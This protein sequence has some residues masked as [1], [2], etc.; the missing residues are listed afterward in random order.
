MWLINQRRRLLQKM[1]ANH[2]YKCEEKVLQWADSTCL[3]L[4]PPQLTFS[5]FQIS[6][7]LILRSMD[8]NSQNFTVRRIQDSYVIDIFSPTRGRFTNIQVFPNEIRNFVWLALIRTQM[9]DRYGHRT[10]TRTAQKRTMTNYF[11]L[12]S[13]ENFVMSS[14]TRG[15]TFEEL[16]VM[17]CYYLSSMYAVS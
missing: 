8:F 17:D 11:C 6:V 13:L 14:L 4:F 7:S 9:G 16:K 12:F 2:L 10:A 5:I 1:S 3:Q 15:T